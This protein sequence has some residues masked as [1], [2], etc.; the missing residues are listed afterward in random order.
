MNYLTFWETDGWFLISGLHFYFLGSKSLS[1]PINLGECKLTP[2]WTQGSEPLMIFSFSYPHL[3]VSTGSFLTAFKLKVILSYLKNKQTNKQTNTA[4]VDLK[5]SPLF[6]SS[7]TSSCIHSSILMAAH[8]NLATQLIPTR[9]SHIS[10]LSSC[11]RTL[12]TLSTRMPLILFLAALGLLDHSHPLETLFPGLLT[13]R[14]SPSPRCPCFF[15]ATF[16]QAHLPLSGQR[17]VKC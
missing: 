10:L 16:S 5:S 3:L 7:Q 8:W 1:I 6:L 4:Y 13:P 15:S 2:S 17:N 9:S 12:R 14:S 11:C